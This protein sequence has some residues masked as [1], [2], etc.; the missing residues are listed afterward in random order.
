MKQFL[1]CRTAAWHLAEEKENLAK[2][3]VNSDD[4]S[5]M[6][7]EEMRELRRKAATTLNSGVVA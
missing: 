7:E 5:K 6:S 1:R 3:L 2:L 4:E